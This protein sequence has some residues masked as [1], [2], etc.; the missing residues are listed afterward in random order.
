MAHLKVF[1]AV[2]SLALVVCSAGSQTTQTTITN[3]FSSLSKIIPDGQFT[4][5]SDS[6]NLSFGLRNYSSITGAWVS[7]GRNLDPAT[8]SESDSPGLLLGSFNGPNPN[9]S[10]T[11]FL[12]DVDFGEQGTVPPWNRVVTAIPE[13]STFGCLALGSLVLG[14]TL[15]RRR[16][17]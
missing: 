2:V 9:G 4:G 10:W 13:P 15:L 16:E 3:T 12:T 8:I 1:G 14:I 11:L 6:H 7:D 17:G 5:V